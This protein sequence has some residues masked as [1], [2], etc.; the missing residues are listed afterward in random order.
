MIIHPDLWDNGEYYGD[1]NLILYH[2]ETIC[3]FYQAICGHHIGIQCCTVVP[4]I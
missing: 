3:R 1:Y 2:G 4:S